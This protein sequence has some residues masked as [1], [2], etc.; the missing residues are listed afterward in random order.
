MFELGALAYLFRTG[1]F[2]WN[3]LFVFYAPFLLFGFWIGVIAWK[4][5]GALKAQ[6]AAEDREAPVPIDTAVGRT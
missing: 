1:P 3:G 6:R 4:L 5:L 2:A